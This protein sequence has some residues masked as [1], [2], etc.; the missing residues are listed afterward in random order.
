[1]SIL[2]SLLRSLIITGIFSFLTPIVFMG[3]ILVTLLG[4][5]HIPHLEVIGLEGIEQFTRF[6]AVFGSGSPVGGVMVISAASTLVGILFD[7]YALYRYQ[8]FRR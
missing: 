1:M 5:G 8:N 6:L 4:L 3:L 7:A 2:P